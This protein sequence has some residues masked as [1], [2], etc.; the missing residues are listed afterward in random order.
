MIFR[1]FPPD[2]GRPERTAPPPDH[3]PLALGRGLG[4]NDPTSGTKSDCP[5]LTSVNR[6]RTGAGATSPAGAAEA[7]QP[8][9][10]GV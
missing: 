5:A 8:N 2:G 9:E 10:C 4:K 6:T 1:D 3:W 7:D